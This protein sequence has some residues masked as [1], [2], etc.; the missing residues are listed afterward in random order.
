MRVKKAK[1]FKRLQ[2]GKK[3]AGLDEWL[4]NEIRAMSAPDNPVK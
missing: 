4:N 1:G 3:A 2:S